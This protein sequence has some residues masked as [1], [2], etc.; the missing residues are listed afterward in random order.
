MAWTQMVLPEAVF[1]PRWLNASVTSRIQGSFS[2][3]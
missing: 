1:S 3:P 2:D